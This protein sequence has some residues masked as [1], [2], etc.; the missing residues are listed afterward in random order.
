MTSQPEPQCGFCGEGHSSFL[1]RSEAAETMIT[2]DVNITVS[3]P[4]IGVWP[5]GPPPDWDGF[6]VLEVMQE[7]GSLQDWAR[8]WAIGDRSHVVIYVPE[9]PTVTG[10]VW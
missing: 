8:D 4:A 2:I 6:D 9:K 10:T 3:L 7:S 1:C 5:D